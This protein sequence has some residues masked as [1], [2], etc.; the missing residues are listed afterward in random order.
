METKASRQGAQ[1]I[2]RAVSEWS[3]RAGCL[4]NVVDTR[5]C[6]RVSSS[7]E[8]GAMPILDSPASMKLS[9]T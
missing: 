7:S 8:T 3:G 4:P 1:K 9:V 5:P 2:T 6:I